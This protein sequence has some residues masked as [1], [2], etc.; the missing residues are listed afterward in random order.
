MWI[1][2]IVPE[3]LS[4]LRSPILVQ[5]WINNPPEW[6]VIQTIDFA[7]DHDLAL[8]DAE[9]QVA[10][11]LAEQQKASLIIND[12]ALARKIARS[13]GLKVTGLLLFCG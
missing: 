4:N 1:P 10:I 5:Q 6:L 7:T 13:R 12:N 11:I 9:E 3:E 8:L 2:K